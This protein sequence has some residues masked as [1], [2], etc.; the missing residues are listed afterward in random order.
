VSTKTSQPITAN[1][2]T[3][4]LANSYFEATRL[5]ERDRALGELLNCI[6]GAS[7]EI[8]E[9]LDYG[10]SVKEFERVVR[11]RLGLASLHQIRKIVE[12]IAKPLDEDDRRRL[13]ASPI[14]SKGAGDEV[15]EDAI[16]F[17]IIMPAYGLF[18]GLR[19]CG[20]NLM[21]GRDIR[22][23]N[24][25]TSAETKAIKALPPLPQGRTKWAKLIVQFTLSGRYWAR[26][27]AMQP[28]GTLFEALK[29]RA[30]RN[31]QGK[32]VRKF[33]GRYAIRRDD[34]IPINDPY[35][36]IEP[37]EFVRLSQDKKLEVI[38]QSKRASKEPLDCTK[39]IR[40]TSQAENILAMEPTKNE[41]QRELIAVVNE[42]L[43]TVP[44]N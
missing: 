10:Y 28:K 2:F 27:D 21:T 35:R 16:Y 32:A 19:E 39:C 38:D 41:L 29:E 7:A 44:R 30:M 24:L 9:L 36:G 13:K 8:T 42:R 12:A 6:A 3:H 34:S 5:G 11:Q 37:S 20:P 15:K 1:A 33:K 4:S 14:K 17:D 43:R 31:R 25:I 18:Y 40:V 26:P 23:G 22:S